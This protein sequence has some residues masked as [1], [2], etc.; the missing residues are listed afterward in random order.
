MCSFVD[1]VGVANIRALILVI[2]CGG[3]NHSLYVSPK[4]RPKSCLKYSCNLL[5]KHVFGCNQKRADYGRRE[6]HCKH[7][8][9]LFFI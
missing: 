4:R 6:E 2:V 3:N 7:D 1:F 5:C 9:T 8:S